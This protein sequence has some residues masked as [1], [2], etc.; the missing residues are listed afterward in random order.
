MESKYI[1]ATEIKDELNIKPGQKI[2]LYGEETIVEGFYPSYNDALERWE[3]IILT[4]GRGDPFE[5]SLDV[6][7]VL[8]V[9]PAEPTIPQQG[10]VTTVFVPCAEDDPRVIGSY[11]STDG[12]SLCHV[13]ESQVPVIE[14]AVWVKGAPKKDKPHYAKVPSKIIADLVYKAIII[15]KGFNGGWWAVGDG[16]SYD[17]AAEEI[18]EHLDEGGEKEVVDG[19]K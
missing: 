12:R 7:E 16:F 15:P 11:T 1:K 9:Q 5:R 17:I 19:S 18:I 13:R 8:M 3:T 10:A 2:K 4:E 6:I 14:G